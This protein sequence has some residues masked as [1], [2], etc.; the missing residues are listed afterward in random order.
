M[1]LSNSLRAVTRHLRFQRKPPGSM[2]GTL[3][4][5]GDPPDESV[6]LQVYTYDGDGLREYAPDDASALGTYRRP[7]ATTWINVDGVHAVDVIEQ[8]GQTFDVHPL[9]LED[10]ISTRQRPKF[11]AYP[12]YLYVV[13]Q[14]IHYD[15]AQ[16]AME[17]EQVSLVIGEG[18]VLSFQEAREGDVFDPVRERL[19]EARGRIR[20]GGTDHLA[21]ALID[22]VV[23]YYMVILEGLGEHIERLE[24]EVVSGPAPHLMQH[25]SQLRH[26]VVFLRR[27]VWPLRDVVAALERSEHPVLSSETSVY[28]RDVYDHTVRTIELIESA[29]EILASLT[30]M[31]LSSLSYRMNEI[32]KVLAIIAT[33]FLPL[34]FIAGIYGMNFDPDASPLNMPELDWYIGYP[35]ALALMAG[36][37]LG[38]WLFFRRR[39][40]L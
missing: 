17:T 23:D 15:H 11:E 30:D 28:F 12:H 26:K 20:T 36:V 7:G 32:M 22:V 4:Y 37:A 34:T 9:T 8:I 25:I 31:H 21:Y 38:M 24:D 3:L 14:M 33:F 10:I 18:Y 29:R 6:R 27:S 13:L 1:N 19:R 5:E 39:G 2:P 40:W 35:F 16:A